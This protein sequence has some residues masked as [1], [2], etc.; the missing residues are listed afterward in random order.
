MP[1]MSLKILDPMVKFGLDILETLMNKKVKDLGFNKQEKLEVQINKVF[2]C[3]IHIS[4]V[5]LFSQ[6]S[7]CT[8]TSDSIH[9]SFVFFPMLLPED[10]GPLM[11]SHQLSHFRIIFMIWI[12]AVSHEPSIKEDV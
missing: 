7:D 6:I 8:F 12:E 11:L 3:I 10:I 9:T 5:R 2:L 4:I 1:R